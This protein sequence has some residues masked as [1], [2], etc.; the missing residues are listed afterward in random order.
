MKHDS[1]GRRRGVVEETSQA[2]KEAE[3]GTDALVVKSPLVHMHP[4]ALSF[5]I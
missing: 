2:Q 4:W 5:I 1:S 3:T